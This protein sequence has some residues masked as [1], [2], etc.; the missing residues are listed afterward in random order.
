MTCVPLTA[1]KG[2]AFDVTLD[3]CSGPRGAVVHAST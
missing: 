1:D 3:M 2:G